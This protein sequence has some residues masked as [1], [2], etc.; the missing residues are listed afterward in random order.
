MTHEKQPVEYECH[1]CKSTDILFDAFAE[2]NPSTQKME[3]N[4]TFDM[5]F[6]TKCDGESRVI[7][8]PYISKIM[9]EYLT[10]QNR[11]GEEEEPDLSRDDAIDDMSGIV[12]YWHQRGYIDGLKFASEVKQ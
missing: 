10:A 7:E 8:I 5:T 9:V 2:W 1:E 12:D 4:S 3:L 6:C 11:L